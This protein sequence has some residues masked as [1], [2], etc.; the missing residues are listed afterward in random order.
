VDRGYKAC[1]IYV[2]RDVDLAIRQA[3]IDLA[4]LALQGRYGEDGCIQGLLEIMGIPYTGSG[5][6]ASALA[7]NKVKSKEIFRLRNLPTPPYYV[8]GRQSLPRLVE[9]H[10]AFG[11]PAVVK[12]ASFGAS[13]GVSL[14]RSLHQLYQAAEQAFM[15][16]STIL[17]ERYID[18]VEVQVAVLDGQPLG[19]IEVVPQDGIYNYL[20]KTRQGRC[21]VHMPARLSATRYQG[22]LTQA[23]K[24]HEALGCS[25]ISLV[26]MILSERGNEFILEVNS[27][28]AL[29]PT[30]MLPKIAHASGLEFGDLVERLVETASLK[31][32]GETVQRAADGTVPDLLGGEAQVVGAAGPN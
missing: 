25:G 32:H 9:D 20:A 5:V 31:S 29:T 24:A 27:L 13:M 11:F 14:V 17:V 19:A 22:I 10:G 1:R 2:D 6:T 23:R 30:S 4:V 16:D 15:F 12:P 21:E 7:M 8:A 18:G 3:G 28:P 26:D